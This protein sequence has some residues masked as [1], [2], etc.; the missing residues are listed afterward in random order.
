M[1]DFQ[2][3]INQSQ[4]DLRK[5]LAE[6]RSHNFEEVELPLSKRVLQVRDVGVI[7]LAIE[8]K[9]PNTMM[10]LVQQLSENKITETQLM[11]EHSA[12][13]GAL[14]NM[15]FVH[16]VVYP[17]VA[18]EPDDEHISPKDFVYGDKMALF[19]WVNREAMIV[20]PFREGNGKSVA[21]APNGQKLREE[22]Q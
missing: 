7:D 22:T 1:S 9:V 17:P 18:E 3:R 10:D 21:P 14:L 2:N 15:V 11:K 6:W 12:E 19:N 20:R 8:G 13:F 5:M 16:A 4:A